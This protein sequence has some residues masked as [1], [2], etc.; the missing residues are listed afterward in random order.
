MTMPHWKDP[1]SRGIYDHPHSTPPHPQ[2]HAANDIGAR[3][4]RQEEFSRWGSWNADRIDTEARHRDEDIAQAVKIQSSR[5]EGLET[6]VQALEVDRIKR[7]TQWRMV[8]TLA[9]SAKSSLRY[10]IVAVLGIL[11]LTGHVT[12]EQVKVLLSAIGF[13]VG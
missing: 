5:M 6:R 10:A 1:R 8:K 11:L 7:R 9:T 3:L 4:A 12:T 2:S 13:P